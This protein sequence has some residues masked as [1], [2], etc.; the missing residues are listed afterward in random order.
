MLETKQARKS[1]H[2]LVVFH[3]EAIYSIMAHA[4]MRWSYF[5]KSTL[6]Y[7]PES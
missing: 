5:D 4:S 7:D 1:K 2:T 3:R 6:L